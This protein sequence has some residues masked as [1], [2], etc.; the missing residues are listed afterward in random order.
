[1]IIDCHSHVW[2]SRETL[3]QAGDFSC[4]SDGQID[5][6]TVQAH[7]LACEPAEKVFVLGF[8]SSLLN[9]EIP[10]ELIKSYV[11]ENPGR[12]FGFAGIDPTDHNC[13]Q[14]I[15][16]IHDAGVFSGLTVSPSC[17]GFHPADSRAMVLYEL[18]QDCALP[19][20]FLQG[21]LLPAQAELSFGQPAALD[22]VARTFP[23]LKIIVSHFG[24]PW[25]D[26]MI[27]LLG[28]HPNVFSDVAGIT[29]KP[30]QAYRTLS[31]AYEHKVID[32]LLFASDFPS[33]SVKAAVETLYNLNKLTIDSVLPA[34]PR[35]QLRGIVERDS[36]SLLGLDKGK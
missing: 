6:A 25:V 27:A 12:V 10:N 17:Q 15:S 4:L 7:R 30:W 31:L 14:Q 2:L 24:Y 32:K 16:E 20:Y 8:V 21:E 22:E 18:A 13:R 11:I 9:A 23:Q 5:E 35:E 19:I 29:D 26:Q 36:L 33:Q 3:G 28:K 1:M 34:I